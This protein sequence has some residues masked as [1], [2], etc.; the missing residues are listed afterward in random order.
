MNRVERWFVSFRADARP[1]EQERRGFDK[2]QRRDFLFTR[3]NTPPSPKIA[4]GH[5]RTQHQEGTSTKRSLAGSMYNG[6]LSH[7]FSVENGAN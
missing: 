6:F 3:C 7:C 4:V 5:G 2:P 1:Q